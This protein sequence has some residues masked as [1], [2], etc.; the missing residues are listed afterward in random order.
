M[1]EII[2]LEVLCLKLINYCLTR[3]SV[4]NFIELFITVGILYDSDLNNRYLDI[5]FQD[6]GLPLNG[7][8]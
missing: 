8:L 6:L 7:S 2:K 3:P 4:I 5:K 1:H